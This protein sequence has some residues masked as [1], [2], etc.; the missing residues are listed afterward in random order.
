ME[1]FASQVT[2][3]RR[4]WRDVVRREGRETHRFLRLL[5][6][7]KFKGTTPVPVAAHDGEGR[8]VFATTLARREVDDEFPDVE[9]VLDGEFPDVEA[10][11]RDDLGAFAKEMLENLVADREGEPG[12]RVAD[13]FLPAVSR[14]CLEGAID[15]LAELDAEGWRVFAWDLWQAAA[16]DEEIRGRLLRGDGSIRLDDLWVLGV[17][18][19][20]ALGDRLWRWMHGYARPIHF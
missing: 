3:N 10:V 1:I 14:V 16:L 6:L 12:R 15:A 5:F 19:A 2:R 11:R 4:V 13:I 17:V 7:D 8:R 9:A 20:M 18:K